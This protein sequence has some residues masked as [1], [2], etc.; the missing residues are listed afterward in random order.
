MG[1]KKSAP[2]WR[3]DTAEAVGHASR[4]SRGNLGPSEFPSHDNNLLIR[5]RSQPLGVDELIRLDVIILEAD[6][7]CCSSSPL[8]C[9][10]MGTNSSFNNKPCEDFNGSADRLKSLTICQRVHLYTWAEL[11]VMEP[12]EVTWCGNAEIRKVDRR[13]TQPTFSTVLFFENP[14]SALESWTH[15]ESFRS[16]RQSLWFLIKIPGPSMSESFSHEPRRPQL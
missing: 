11:R 13:W 2:D 9:L 16:P 12:R 4:T 15:P 10:E 5:P 1:E 14:V 8:C 3:K 6:P 7:S